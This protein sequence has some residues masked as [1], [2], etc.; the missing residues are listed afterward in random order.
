MRYAVLALDLDGT[1]TNS[2]KK[3]T[4]L[5]KQRVLEARR[6]GV[7]I[8]LASGR[9]ELGIRPLAR[10]LDFYRSGGYI[11]SNNGSRI[12]DC[13]TNEALFERT[14]PAELYAHICEF[15]RAEGLSALAYDDHGVLSENPEDEYV[16]KEAFNNG[17]PIRRVPLL[18]QAVS[19]P[20]NKFMIVGPPPRLQA[21]LP[22]LK[23]NIGRKVNIFLS[24]PYFME[25]SP[26]EIEKAYAM[27]Q[28]L[29]LLGLNKSQLAFCGDGLNDLT[30]M[31]L[32]GLGIAMGNAC[33]EIKS[34]SGFIT[35]SNEEDGVAY[36]IERFILPY[37]E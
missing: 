4:P 18:E 27:Q 35:R 31:R 11:L 37:A 25:I 28:L 22:T 8:V 36:A 13:K 32:A 16:K 30:L 29:A 33:E 17:I 19:W 24:E 5:T 1:L 20:V 2:K 21:A 34:A 6:A 12:L 3:I 26:P 10:E 9:P 14:V 7:Q 15:A 23:K